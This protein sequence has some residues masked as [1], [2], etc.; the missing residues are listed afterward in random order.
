[1]ED[2][3]IVRFR[4]DGVLRKVVS[5]PKILQPAIVSRIKILSNLKI[6][7]TAPAPRWSFSDKLNKN[8]IDFRIST[9]PTVNG[10]KVVARI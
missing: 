5:L 9:L 3:V 4:V 2:E 10:E 8:K 7:R 6:E 1:M